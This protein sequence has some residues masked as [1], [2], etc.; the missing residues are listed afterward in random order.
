[1]NAYINSLIAVM[2]VC[3]IA[4]VIA[5][6]S[7]NAGR[8]IRTVCAVVALLTLLAPAKHLLS[9]SGELVDRVTS[10][11]TADITQ[12]YDE[13]DSAAAG[14]MQYIISQYDLDELSA[15]ILTDETDTTITGIRL[16]IPECPYPRRMVMES[17]LQELLGLPVSVFSE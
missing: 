12:S 7:D 11:F 6:D 15:V 16:Y 9:R 2:V 14:L 1:M 10:F 8:C 3:Q 4:V 5:P 13:N 17:E